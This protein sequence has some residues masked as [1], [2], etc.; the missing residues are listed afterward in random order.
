MRVTRVERFLMTIDI[1]NVVLR[2]VTSYRLVDTL[3]YTGLRDREP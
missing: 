3:K 1:K 2:D